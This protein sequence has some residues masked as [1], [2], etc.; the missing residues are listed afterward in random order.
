MLL[1]RFVVGRLLDGDVD[2]QVLASGVFYGL[3]S[4]WASNR[5][6]WVGPQHTSEAGVEE[7]WEIESMSALIESLDREAKNAEPNPEM[8]Q[9]IFHIPPA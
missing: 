7:E 1:L 3:V 9:S 4:R 5:V 8:S 2:V 6:E